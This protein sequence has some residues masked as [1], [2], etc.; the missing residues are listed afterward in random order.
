MAMHKDGQ[1]QKSRRNYRQHLTTSM[2]K[3]D[4][5]KRNRGARSEVDTQRRAGSDEFDKQ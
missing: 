4:S 2:C 5:V 3:D 1:R